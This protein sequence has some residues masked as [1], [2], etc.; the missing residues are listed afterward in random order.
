MAHLPLLMKDL[1]L[2]LGAAAITTL[3]FRRLKQPLVLGYVIAGLLVGPHF[4]FFPTVGDP[5]NIKIWADIGVVILL[6]SLGLEFS[7][8]KLMRVGGSASIA[9]IFE[10]SSMLL[11]GYITGT[12]L[13]WSQMNSIFL[14]GIIAI[15]STT[16][17]IRAFDEQGMK[18]TSFAGL[19]MGML[20]IEDIVAVLLMVLLSTVAVSQQFS[21]VALL[22][23]VVKLLFFL[24]LWFLS[25]ILILPS[26]FRWVGKWL[27]EETLLIIALGLC[28]AMVLLATQM[29][30]SA[31]LG[32]FIMGSV[33]AETSQ[34]ET[35]EHQ[36]QPVKNLFGAIFFVSVGMLIDPVLL[37][38]YKWPVLLIT[39]AVMLGKTIFV[40][41]GSF[42]SGQPLKQSLQA[43]MSMSQIGEFS[44]IIAT[45][46]VSLGVTEDFLY[47][48]AVGV[49][50]ITTFTTPFMIR[51]SQPI[52]LLIDEKL[53]QKWRNRL[54][55]Y[56]SSAQQLPAEADWKVVFRG[57]FI[58]IALNSVVILA[59]M[60]L[61]VR[62]LDPWL[63]KHLGNE[64]FSH[65]LTVIVTLII[66]APF[67]WALTIKKLHRGSYTSLWLNS[68]LN[69][70]PLVLV[71]VIRN[72]LAVLYLF[73][74]LNQLFPVN[75]AFFGSVIT[76]AV[77]LVIFSRKLQAFYARIEKRFM[78]NL[79][80]R[81]L[82]QNT[83][84]KSTLTPWDAHL[85]HF[86]IRPEAAC[87]GKS[88]Q[89][90]AW[91]ERFG[92]NVASIERGAKMITTPNRDELVFPF[93][94][95]AV[96]GTDQQLQQFRQ[97]VEPAVPIKL[98]EAEEDIRLMK[99]KVDEHNLL[100][101]K[102]IRHSGVREM[103]NGLVVGIER[104]GER[105][106]NPDSTM[107]FEWDDIVWIVGE[108]NK[109]LEL[110]A[111]A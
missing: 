102:T 108:R 18:A 60:F 70:G 8:K 74:L 96:I 86:V 10:I 66:S 39:I 45:L 98:E 97:I 4:S 40:T 1:A 82:M 29:G 41:I 27:N 35:I 15:S 32:A 20:V 101:G 6:F 80:H 93:D 65:I 50:V 19:V 14:G 37:W 52:Y 22:I 21:G 30:F 42:I 84:A 95:L 38:K 62:F 69:H 47:P 46:G 111:K 56:S 89:T 100:K 81:E 103:T 34:A 57:Y 49:S 76:L 109:I 55:R 51:A 9:G 92:I 68:Q 73:L 77:V 44:F 28:L 24:S 91:R 72:L 90:L 53:P 106:L 85:A 17:I 78:T 67:I 61:A 87:V 12:M 33:L 13:G 48:I 107:V 25:G 54:N 99:I 79:H 75:V 83:G 94:K 71:E 64:L 11:L 16:I 36:M 2:I 3:I 105:I 5:E 43:G 59:V 110:T 58:A 104:N 23:E 31:A 88:L 63:V 7:F 26:F